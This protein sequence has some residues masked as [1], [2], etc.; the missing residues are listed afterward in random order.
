MILYFFLL[1]SRSL[2][3][4]EGN[5]VSGWVKGRKVRRR[6]NPFDPLPWEEP[7]RGDAERVPGQVR[8]KGLGVPQLRDPV[9]SEERT[10]DVAE[11]RR[12]AG[13]L[14]ATELEAVDREWGEK[15][16]DRCDEMSSELNKQERAR[17]SAWCSRWGRLRAFLL[18]P[19]SACVA[20]AANHQPEQD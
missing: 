19:R 14:C 8:D 4:V 5:I 18:S 17:K 13:V 1:P 3:C 10:N 11:G 2:V 20:S 7:P 6:T 15:D 9:A 16:E 12:A